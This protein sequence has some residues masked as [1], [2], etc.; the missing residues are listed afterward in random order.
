MFQTTNLSHESH[1]IYIYKY[2]YYNRLYLYNGTSIL[3]WSYPWPM[4]T[5]N[6]VK[7]EK[8]SGS[9]GTETSS[10]RLARIPWR[11]GSVRYVI[12]TYCMTYYVNIWAYLSACLA[13]FL[14]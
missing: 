13:V 12:Y 7:M 10:L 2:A 5:A 4:M 1:D 3:P 9:C 14:I 6:E 8:K 11:D